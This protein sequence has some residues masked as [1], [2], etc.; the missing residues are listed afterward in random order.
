M[1]AVAQAPVLAG[2]QLALRRGTAW[3]FK[4]LHFALHAGEVLWLRGPNGC[5]KTSLLRLAVG[6][7]QPDAGSMAWRGQ[8]LQNA[9]GFAQ[10]LVYIGHTQAL[11][12]ELT[13]A[14]SLAFLAT[15]H[16]RPST[17]SA[18]AAALK[19]FSVDARRH[20]SVRVLSQGQRKRVAL[21]RLALESRPGIWVLDEP[22]DALD[23]EGMDVV[24]ALVS[25]HIARGGCV[26]L[27]S[28]LPRPL[29]ATPVRTLDLGIAA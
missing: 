29:A 28:H 27:T 6:L 23:A 12:D 21:A 11:K 1:D 20:Q 13:V 4:E 2:H 7:I 3:L 25:H 16:G 10:E 17:P 26:L 18:I 19:Q 9:D 15:L 14:E 22:Y 5:G 24:D 8:P